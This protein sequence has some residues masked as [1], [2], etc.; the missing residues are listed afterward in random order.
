MNK[1]TNTILFMLIATLFNIVSGVVFFLALFF[2]YARF[3]APRLSES[4]RPWGLPVILFGS[5]GLSVVSYH[6]LVRI[7]T[8]RVNLEKHFSPLFSPGKKPPRRGE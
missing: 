4:A 1:K 6:I 5:F 7:F 2:V 3:V 8:K